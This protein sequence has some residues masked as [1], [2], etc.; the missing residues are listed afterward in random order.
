MTH[1]PI[2]LEIERAEAGSVVTIREAEESDAHGLVTY[3]QQA[4]QETE[5][6]AFKTT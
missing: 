4:F 3:K 1:S 2:S 6:H 5:K